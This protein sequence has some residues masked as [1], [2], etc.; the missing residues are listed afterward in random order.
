MVEPRPLSIFCTSGLSVTWPSPLKSAGRTLKRKA[1][2]PPATWSPEGIGA[3]GV[4]PL[5]VENITGRSGHGG[6]ARAVELDAQ[7]VS[8]R[9]RGQRPYGFEVSGDAR[10][11]SEAGEAVSGDVD[12]GERQVGQVDADLPRQSGSGSDRCSTRAARRADRRCRRESSSRLRPGRGCPARRE[13][14]ASMRCRGR[15]PQ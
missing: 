12:A 15:G 7:L 8:H 14:A 6:A 1:K 4:G 10:S 2:S 9:R 11:R 3:D 5:A 13:T